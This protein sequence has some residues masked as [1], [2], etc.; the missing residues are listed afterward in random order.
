M[1]TVDKVA[2]GNSQQQVGQRP[3][4]HEQDVLPLNMIHLH[5]STRGKGAKAFSIGI[6]AGITINKVVALQL[7][8]G[9]SDS[10]VFDCFMHEMLHNLRRDPVTKNKKIAV[11][12]DNCPI[13]RKADVQELAARFNVLILFNAQYSPWLAPVEQLFNF[14]KRKVG[15]AINRMTR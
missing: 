8:E 7:I 4:I 14:Y 13:H 3:V 10:A 2:N 15:S 11:L 5:N 12:I 1:N 6:F 9:S